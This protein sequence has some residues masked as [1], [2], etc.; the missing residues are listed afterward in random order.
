MSARPNDNTVHAQAAARR[1]GW[2]LLQCLLDSRYCMSRLWAHMHAEHRQAGALKGFFFRVREFSR[3]REV[4]VPNPSLN[5]PNDVGAD[6]AREAQHAGRARAGAAGG[7]GGEE[8][9]AEEADAEGAGGARGEGVRG[10]VRE[11]DWQDHP[12]REPR[13]RPTPDWPAPDRPATH[14][15]APCV[16]IR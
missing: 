11:V 14:A 16:A 13:G 9:E 1:V 7:G 12:C 2:H 5:S 15:P 3:V 10:G 8:A 6:D 4:T